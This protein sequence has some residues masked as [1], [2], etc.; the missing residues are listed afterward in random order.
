MTWFNRLKLAGG[1]LLVVVIV[2]ACTVVFNQR[3]HRA[4]STSA[5]IVAQNYPVGTD[6]GGIVTRQ[7]VEVGDDVAV[8]D[9]LFDVRSL[10]LQRDIASGQVAD[11]VLAAS[12][13]GDGT[14]T[15]VATV[16]GTVR[17]VAVPQGGFA[18]AGS[19]LATVDQDASLFVEAEF[20]LSARDYARITE[21]SHV[22]LLLPNQSVLGG[23]VAGIDVETAEGQ[24]L[25]TLR[26]T[27][28][29][30]SQRAATGLF[31]AGTPVQATLQL[32]D[33][34]PLAGVGDA[35]RDLLQKVGL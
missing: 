18:Q 9:P 32:R 28:A 25:S 21:G 11:P 13:A 6:Y 15:I 4:L 31:Q 2:M 23:D 5:T 30:L 29:D 8:G 35:L 3:Q 1:I 12:V 19:V 20:L 24:A 33:D 14:S 22:E 10:Q 34:G 17:E 7:Y 26:I 16:D 27:S